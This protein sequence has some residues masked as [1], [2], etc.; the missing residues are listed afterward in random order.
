MDEDFRNDKVAALILGRCNATDKKSISKARSTGP[1]RAK[2]ASVFVAFA[3]SKCLELS[4]QYNQYVPIFAII[5]S[6]CATKVISDR[7]LLLKCE[8]NIEART[9]IPGF[10]FK[11][12]NLTRPVGSTLL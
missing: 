5:A 12:N 2:N 8:C 3:Y 9:G 1:A 10:V 6:L 4:S 7:G 11:Q